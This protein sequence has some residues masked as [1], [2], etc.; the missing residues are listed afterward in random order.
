MPTVLVILGALIIP[1]AELLVAMSLVD[2]WPLDAELLELDW[3]MDLF[4]QPTKASIA[5]TIAN[6]LQ[7]FHV[8][9]IL[10]FHFCA[11]RKGRPIYGILA[12]C[13]PS[14]ELG[15]Y[16]YICAFLD[17]E[18]HGRLAFCKVLPAEFAFRMTLIF[19]F[20]MDYERHRTERHSQA[21][22]HAAGG[23]MGLERVLKIK[24]A[25]TTNFS[26]TCDLSAGTNGRA[27]NLLRRC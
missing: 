17:Y 15:A 5:V 25:L 12:G 24:F 18:R 7:N 4:P 21:G 3:S 6:A 13:V 8:F 9:I 26:L 16:T 11:L 22:C 1:A 10:S 2:I 19:A 14:D 27:Q 23:T 20:A